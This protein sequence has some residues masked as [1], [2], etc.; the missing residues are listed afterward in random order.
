M[1]LIL[2]VER[3]NDI[4]FNG[5]IGSIDLDIPNYEIPNLLDYI[6]D[7]YI[8]DRIGDNDLIDELEKRGYKVEE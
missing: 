6:P 2:D 8:L 3:V 1:N 5:K 4:S 7:G